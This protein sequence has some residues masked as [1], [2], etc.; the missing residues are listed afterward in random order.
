MQDTTRQSP[1]FK[2]PLKTRAR[3]AGPRDEAGLT[4][5]PPPSAFAGAGRAGRGG[6]GPQGLPYGSQ[7]PRQG[8]RASP[9]PKSRE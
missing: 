1:V 3:E 6:R 7:T 2:N 9:H 5:P 8:A 4:F